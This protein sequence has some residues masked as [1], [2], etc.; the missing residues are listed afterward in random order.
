MN[1]CFLNVMVIVSL[2]QI[3]LTQE[4]TIKKRARESSFQFLKTMQESQWYS[5]WFN[6]GKK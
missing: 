3:Q 6:G 1:K 4:P 2:L 5:A